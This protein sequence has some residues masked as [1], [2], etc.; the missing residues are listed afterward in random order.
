MKK[1]IKIIAVF[2]ILIGMANSVFATTTDIEVTT[3]FVGTASDKVT[4]VSGAIWATVATIVQILA[5]GAIVG[6]G[7]T[8]MFSSADKKAD[9]KKGAI[10]LT[11][12]AGLVFAA[13]TIVRFI[14][15]IGEEVL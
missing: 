8:Y 4:E 14:A 15:D 12:G 11:I 1:T 10:K 2:L 7:L 5:V 6:A 13:T 3:D 9:I